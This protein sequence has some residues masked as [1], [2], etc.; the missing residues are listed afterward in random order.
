MDTEAN[1]KPKTAWP[2]L[3]ETTLAYIRWQEE[4]PDVWGGRTKMGLT[5]LGCGRT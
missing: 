5:L 1:D 2:E 4:N 3:N